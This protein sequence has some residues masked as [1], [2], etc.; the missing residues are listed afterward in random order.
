MG[1][2]YVVA[3]KAEVSVTALREDL[4]TAEI[5][6][7]YGIPTSVINRWRREAIEHIKADSTNVK[8]SMTE[9]KAS[10]KLAN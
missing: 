6:K 3:T 7:R 10:K 1:T 4:M 5:S 8:R 2:E 9:K